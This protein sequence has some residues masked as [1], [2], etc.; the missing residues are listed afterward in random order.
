VKPQKYF[1]NWFRAA[2]RNK[3]FVISFGGEA[4]PADEFDPRVH[5]FALLN[6]LGIRLVLVHGIFAD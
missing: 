5:D 3:T 4:V 2:Y 1:I 6:S